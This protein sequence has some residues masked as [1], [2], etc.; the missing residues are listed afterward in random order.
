MAYL[1]TSA[2]STCYIR[3]FKTSYQQNR[4]ESRV[5]VYQF[6][7]IRSRM[8]SSSQSFRIRSKVGVHKSKLRTSLVRNMIYS[9]TRIPQ[10]MF[11][12]RS[13][14][15]SYCNPFVKILVLFCNLLLQLMK[16]L[17]KVLKIT[18]NFIS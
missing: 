11:F 12:K 4:S 6:S 3:L 17:S 8:R 9:R 10:I 7:Q 15:N 18:V 1:S 16:N 14:I 13:S 5:R 2:I